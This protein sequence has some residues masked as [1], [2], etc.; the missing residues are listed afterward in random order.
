MRAGRTI[1]SELVADRESRR[2]VRRRVHETAFGVY[3]PLS[4]ESRQAVQAVLDR[5]KVRVDE[6]FSA[7]GGLNKYT[8]LI[9][10]PDHGVTYVRRDNVLRALKTSAMR[11]FSLNR[12]QTDVANYNYRNGSRLTVPIEKLDWFGA[13]GVKLVATFEPERSTDELAEDSE[14]IGIFLEEAGGQGLDVYE[15]DHATLCRFRRSRGGHQ[16]GLM[17]KYEVKSIVQEELMAASIGAITLE[18]V[19]VGKQGYS[20]AAQPLVPAPSLA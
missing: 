20:G 18:E 14:Q 8:E 15:P 13:Q 1:R 3:R 7:Q 9:I 11:N 4:D 5:A 16:L 12:V 2:D 10:P 6:H 17:Q 19:V